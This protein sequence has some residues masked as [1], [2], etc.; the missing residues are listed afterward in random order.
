MS[1]FF[2]NNINWDE[3]ELFAMLSPQPPQQQQQSLSSLNVVMG[4]TREEEYW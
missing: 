2:A 3:T 4:F 1:V